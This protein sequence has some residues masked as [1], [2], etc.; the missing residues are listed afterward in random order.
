MGLQ[1][2]LGV[3]GRSNRRRAS[4]R[5]LDLQ[6]IMDLEN[7]WNHVHD[8]P[9]QS[10]SLQQREPEIIKIIKEAGLTDIAEISQIETIGLRET[11]S[12]FESAEMGDVFPRLL[13]RLV[14]TSGNE[15][16]TRKRGC[17]STHWNG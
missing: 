2:R 7:L 8:S 16:T 15:A 14:Q 9:Y 6:P 3:S 4:N 17:T 5:T 1:N 12:I 10:S 11:Q 13:R